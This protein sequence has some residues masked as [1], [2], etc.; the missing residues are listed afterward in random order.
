MKKLLCVLFVGLFFIGISSPSFAF[1]NDCDAIMSDMGR[2]DREYRD[3]KQFEEEAETR[4]VATQMRR[5]AKQNRNQHRRLTNEFEK[6][7]EWR[8]KQQ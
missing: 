3:L 1:R 6:C 8:K 4:N 7:I 5:E 2:C